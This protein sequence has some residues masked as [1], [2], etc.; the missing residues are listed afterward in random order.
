[1][2]YR[3]R[4]FATIGEFDPALDVG[5]VTQGGGDLDM[6]FR[7][8]Q[9][10]LTLV[11]EPAAIVRH[12]HRRT[13]AELHKQLVGWGIGLSAVIR[14]ERRDAPAGAGC[15]RSLR[16]LAFLEEV[17]PSA[18]LS[19]FSPPAVPRALIL[20]ELRGAIMGPARYR[21]ARAAAAKIVASSPQHAVMD[22][23]AAVK[24]KA[25]RG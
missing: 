12:R 18:G 1:M 17:H 22:H 11:Y 13:Q 7:V 23:E 25:P 4:V 8:I 5:T 24:S 2:A 16:A 10:G 14:P 15:D 20:A 19:V 21:Q 9:H 6:F 3:R